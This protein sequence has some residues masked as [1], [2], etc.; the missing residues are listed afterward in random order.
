MR[1]ALPLAVLLGCAIDPPAGACDTE[2]WIPADAPLA[3]PMRAR[4][5]ITWQAGSGET[6]TIAGTLARADEANATT[7]LLLDTA[8]GELELEIAL[9]RER[10]GVLP[11]GAAVEA[12]LGPGIVLAGDD[13]RILTAVISHRGATDAVAANVTFRQSYAECVARVEAPSCTR[14]MA[15]PLV[16]VVTGASIVRL[17]PGA[18]WRIPDDEDPSAEIE[19]VR[20]VRAPT[21]DELSETLCAEQP[22]HE[23]AAIVRRLR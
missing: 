11:I 13:G 12:R 8:D 1:R 2:T 4:G 21:S 5:A 23:L 22:A 19:I 18:T 6:I 16:D 10:L 7:T 20:S 3:I 14:A 9:P 17:P 15:T